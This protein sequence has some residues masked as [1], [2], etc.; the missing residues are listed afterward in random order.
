MGSAALV[1]AIM[2]GKGSK[3]VRQ[4]EGQLS[5]LHSEK[6]AL[7]RT[8]DELTRLN[9]QLRERLNSVI[10]NSDAADG[11]KVLEE[12]TEKL[13]NADLNYDMSKPP[14]V[15][16]RGATDVSSANGPE[17]PTTHTP[18]TL[19]S[20][21]EEKYIPQVS[22]EG[23][24]D[25][26]FPTS[27][28]MKVS[29][30]ESKDFEPMHNVST[31]ISESY[32]DSVQWDNDKI[33]RDIMQNFFDG[34]GQTLDGVR[35]HFE[36]TAN[37]TYKVRIEGQST[38]TPDKAVFIGESSKR[39]DPNAAGNYGEGLKMA[40]LKL[41]RDKGAKNVNI[42][43][44]NWR[45]SY[46]LADN[47]LS[48]KRVLTYSMDKTP[49]YDGNYVE[50][51]TSDKELLEKF[52]KTLGRFYSSGNTHFKCPDFENATFGVKK[53]GRGEKGGLYIAGQRF[54]F[55]G[56]YDGLSEVALFLKRKPPVSVLD[57]SRDRTSINQSQL[58]EIARWLARECTTESEKLELIKAL[59]KYGEKV[60]SSSETPMHRFLQN[61]VYW[62]DI[63]SHD[64]RGVKFPS[65]YVAYSPCSPDI[66]QELFQAGYKVFH[67][68]FGTI[69]MRNIAN[70]YG[71]AQ[72][73]TAVIPN[74]IQRK[75]LVILQ[76]ALKRL[77][78]SLEGKHFTSSELDSKIFMFDR[79]S[80]S[81]NSM[82]RSTMA[83]AIVDG[84]SSKGFWIDK[85]YLDDANFGDVLETALHEL[86]HKVGGDNSSTFGYKLTEV[87][88]EVIKQIINDP[89]TKSELAALSKMWDDL[90]NI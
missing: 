1:G 11:G 60:S 59:E 19:R 79:Y 68:R 84:G 58:D 65:N 43:S 81:E 25:Y 24:F 61:F 40:A 4:L 27:S 83:E 49:K 28:E 64:I 51:E 23:R 30:I 63:G 13:K 47:P 37:G 2:H 86:S 80:A 48:E 62:C 22:S 3:V 55:E 57:P 7:Q 90:K 6:S 16:R 41:L 71:E 69:G 21:I 70:I 82:Y 35:L 78:P 67:D 50:F 39:N 8:T 26:E 9:N 33:A 72:K 46:S 73:H 87:N 53:I 42:G 66:M 14:V 45:I 74:D 17:Y 34:H 89:K 52:R 32:A 5:N 88:K 15:G 18:T 12:M 85:S 77:A 20:N 44:D 31:S 54:E 76:E 75:K 38:Y 36:P 10:S 56:D 29:K